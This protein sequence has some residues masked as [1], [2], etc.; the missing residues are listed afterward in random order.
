MG[1][2][3]INLSLIVRTE[4]RTPLSQ[5]LVSEPNCWQLTACLCSTFLI[6]CNNLMQDKHSHPENYWKNINNT[7]T[8]KSTQIFDVSKCIH[9]FPQ[10]HQELFL[11]LPE[12]QLGRA[13]WCSGESTFPWSLLDCDVILL[14]MQ[15]CLLDLLI[16]W[17]H[18][19]W[20]NM[21]PI[22]LNIMFDP[23]LFP[24]GAGPIQIMMQYRKQGFIFRITPWGQVAVAGYP[25]HTHT[26]CSFSPLF[27]LFCEIYVTL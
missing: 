12:P 17:H 23:D 2:C 9:R 15:K 14:H 24:F 18:V 8:C 25:W 3:H 27:L 1:K 5:D 6:I 20:S 4:V 26:V 21:Q 10:L 7:H 22:T 16:G 11:L 13:W 19:K